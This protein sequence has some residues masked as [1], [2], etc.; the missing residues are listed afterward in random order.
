[1]SDK[2]EAQEKTDKYEKL[3]PFTPDVDENQVGL[4]IEQL[5]T[6]IMEDGRKFL[7]WCQGLVDTVKKTN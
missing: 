3:Q 6:V 2:L 5:W 1:M 7:Q 4:E